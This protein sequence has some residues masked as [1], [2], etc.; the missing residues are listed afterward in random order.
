MDVKMNSDMGRVLLVSAC[1]AALTVRT[2]VPA[3]AANQSS[4]T[5]VTCSS[6]QQV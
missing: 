4:T 3:F 5:S 6:S 1:A 2:D